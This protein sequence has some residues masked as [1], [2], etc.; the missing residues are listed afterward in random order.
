M[1]SF[2]VTRGRDTHFGL[3]LGAV[4]GLVH[5]LVV[6]F[7]GIGVV[8]V[9]VVVGILFFFLDGGFA[10]FA[11]GGGGVG[12]E[13]GFGGRVDELVL[14]RVFVDHELG[15]FE[16]ALEAGVFEDGARGGCG[17]SLG[18]LGG[19]LAVFAVDVL[20]SAALVEFVFLGL[21]TLG[22]TL[23][24]LDL[25]GSL[26]AAKGADAGFALFVDL[27][28]DDLGLLAL[29]LEGV[30]DEAG[31]VVEALVHEVTVHVR[32]DNAGAFAG[33]EEVVEVELA[34]FGLG[35]ELVV[36]VGC[37]FGSGGGVGVGVVDGA[38]RKLLDLGIEMRA[39][40]GGRTEGGKEEGMHLLAFVGGEDHTTVGN[41]ADVVDVDIRLYRHPRCTVVGIEQLDDLLVGSQN[42][43]FLRSLCGQELQG[44]YREPVTLVFAEERCSGT[45]IV[46]GDQTALVSGG[47]GKTV[48][49]EL[50]R[51]DHWCL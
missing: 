20:G 43:L 4:L 25:V 13:G 31:F 24:D 19:F 38:V 33:G 29:P 36:V 14:E 34:H 5:L 27:L 28:A 21:E 37:G 39:P 16:E 23:V 3:L 42:L 44:V 7:G 18:F 49:V 17:G 41:R 50:C 26:V 2:L 47:E 35:E 40:G 1:T 30:G 9:A 46:E 45:Q 11:L 8:A 48:V 22:E 10:A 12:R 6:V 15:V 51:R 32:T